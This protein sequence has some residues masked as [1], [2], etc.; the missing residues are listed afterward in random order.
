MKIINLDSNDYYS[1]RNNSIKPSQACMPTSYVMFLLAN[2]IPFSNPSDYQD[3]DYFMSLLNT[4]EAKE[5]CYKN[6]PWA[7][8]DV[9]P[10][11]SLP[12]N[13]LHGMY[14]NYLSPLVCDGKKVSSFKTNLTFED[15]KNRIDAGKAIMTSV[16]IPEMKIN[17]HAILVMG[18]IDDTLLLADPWGNYHTGYKNHRGYN[19]EMNKEDF[20]KYVKPIGKKEKWGHIPLV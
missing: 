19:I 20:M 1:Q 12:P 8:N 16:Y 13:E 10:E 6:Y 5:Y 17:G 3:D 14:G 2:K 15:Y 9:F 7:Y 4:E 11:Q 18:R